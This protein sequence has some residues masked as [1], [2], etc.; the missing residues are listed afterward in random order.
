[1]FPCLTPL[2]CLH[3]SH[4]MDS[5]ATI[6]AHTLSI[7]HCWGCCRNFRRAAAAGEE[8]KEGV[9]N[10]LLRVL[11]AGYLSLVDHSLCRL[12]WFKAVLMTQQ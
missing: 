11:H 6:T 10:Q 12:Y 5:Q 7:K 2:L 8:L 1:M 3:T 9:V 4:F